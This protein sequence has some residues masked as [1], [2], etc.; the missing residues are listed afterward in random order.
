MIDPYTRTGSNVTAEDEIAARA[1]TLIRT[2]LRG[3]FNELMLLQRLWTTNGM[4]AKIAAAATAE[5]TLAGY[6]PQ[7]WALWGEVLRQFLTWFQTENPAM[8]ALGGST[9][10]AA[11]FT[12]YTME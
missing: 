1:Q 3:D 6:S 9:P 11:I 5:T 10:E 7:T 8:V 12:N 2:A 4:E